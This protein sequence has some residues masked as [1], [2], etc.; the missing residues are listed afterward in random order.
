MQQYLL[1]FIFNSLKTRPIFQID[2]SAKLSV[3]RQSR[4]SRRLSPVQKCQ[5]RPGL[6]KDEFS[7][8]STQ[9]LNQEMAGTAKCMCTCYPGGVTNRPGDLDRCR[10]LTVTGLQ[11]CVS[12]SIRGPHP[13]L[14][15]VQG[16]STPHHLWN[17][18]GCGTQTVSKGT[19]WIFGKSL[20]T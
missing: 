1:P 3:T 15:F 12:L 16:R 9:L 7:S 6:W 10:P 20:A 14:E 17:L 13:M 19:H 8:P 2:S 5:H 11:R 4:A 18:Q